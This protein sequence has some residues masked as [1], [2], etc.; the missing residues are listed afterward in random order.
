LLA[1]LCKEHGNLKITLYNKKKSN[2]IHCHE[3]MIAAVALSHDGEL[4]AT[5]S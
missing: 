3:N 4:I 1:C 2:T 5:A